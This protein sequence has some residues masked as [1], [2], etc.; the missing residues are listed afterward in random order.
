MN[1]S[2]YI[3]A[4]SFIDG[5]GD[6]IR[7]HVVMTIQ[8]GMITA[9]SSEADIPCH[10]ATRIDDFSHCTIVP[11]LIDCSVALSRSPSVDLSRG[12]TSDGEG[13]LE[14]RATLCKRHIQD[15]HAHGVLGV[16]DSEDAT[17]P[18]KQ[19]RQELLNE[20]II[21]I[22]T[23][24]PLCR[25]RHDTDSGTWSDHEPDRDF[26]KIMYSETIEEQGHP[27]SPPRL[28]EKALR[29]LLRHRRNKQK[30]VVVANGQQAVADAL[31]A[32]CDAIEQGYLMGE[33]NLRTMAE[34]KVL[35]IPSL[36]RA[37]NLLDGSGS[38]GDVCCRFS[39]RY[40]AP[41]KAVPGAEALWK[42]MLATQ[43]AQLEFARALGVTTAVGTGAGRTGILHGES[44]V[45]EM[46]L[47][48]K[49]GYSLV[50]TIR[51]AT[52][53]GARFFGMEDLGALKVG[54]QATFL[55]TRGTP[56]QLPRKLAYLEGIYVHGAPSSA[57]RKNPVKVVPLDP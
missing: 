56:Q 30:V 8:N 25:G 28:D 31:A 44:V 24:G 42:K 12:Q 36:V 4:G 37:K 47:F 2:R 51:C 57:Y 41:G 18:T 26:L 10:H 38:G 35:W 45:E 11:A 39:Q 15:C 27:L 16:A 55:I 14:T 23:S 50:D 53:N 32:G 22:R 43:L 21:S 7:K 48:L 34:K 5:T 20:S 52:E 29:D 33:D 19:H 3:I 13:N 40:V 17:G 49:A 54:R 46:K 6:A 9:I 1:I